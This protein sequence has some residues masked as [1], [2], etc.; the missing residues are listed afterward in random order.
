MAKSP[1]SRFQRVVVAGLAVAGASAADSL[2]ATTSAEAGCAASFA[3]FAIFFFAA[4]CND[5]PSSSRSC[6]SARAAARS[7]AELAS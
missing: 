2:P 4:F 3:F 1:T 6:A 7:A 5:A